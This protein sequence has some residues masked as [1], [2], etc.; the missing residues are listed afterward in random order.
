MPLAEMPAWAI[1]GIQT[2]IQVVMAVMAAT[3]HLR[4]GRFM[5]TSFNVG[6]TSL[7]RHSSRD[8]WACQ[9]EVVSTGV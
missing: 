7:V 5:F 8:W 2:R 9:I 3:S 4:M 1:V 6:S